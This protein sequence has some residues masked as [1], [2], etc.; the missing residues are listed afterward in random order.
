MPI[1][2]VSRRVAEL[3][4]QLGVRLLERSTRN[5]RLSDIGA[6]ILA[7]A[8]RA[9]ELSEALDL[10]VSNQ[11]STVA[12]L[13]RLS[14][15]PSIS[16]TLLAPLLSAFLAS[17]PHVRVEVLVTERHV[18]HIAEGIDLAFRIGTLRDSSLIARS[19]LTYRRQ[20]VAAP[21]YLQRTEPPEAPNDL[22]QH[23]LLAFARHSGDATWTF[24]HRN[25][26]RQTVSFV[27][28]LT[29]NDYAG[30][31]PPLLTGAGIGELP[32]VVQPELLR[33]G[34]LVEVMPD[35][36]FPTWDLSVVHLGNRH[37]QRPVRVFKEFA[38]QMAPTLFPDLPK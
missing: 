7:H 24:V 15:P 9:V 20:L 32:P 16:D 10:A 18:D 1:S 38:A 17:Y 35:W 13:L 12:G 25:G 27:P 6:E 8:E 14:V 11:R 3:E 33:E 31:T 5:L 4:D 23:R 26:E 2:T 30:L 36:R 28:Y 34:R 21:A 19:I 29:M 37:I 22:L